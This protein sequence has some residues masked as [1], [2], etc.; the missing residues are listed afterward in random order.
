MTVK[1]I[2]VLVPMQ[3]WCTHPFQTH[4]LLAEINTDKL[5]LFRDSILFNINEALVCAVCVHRGQGEASFN[6]RGQCKN[7]NI[8]ISKVLSRD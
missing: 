6:H 4:P 1:Q 8:N 2:S 3:S 7:Q 5:L